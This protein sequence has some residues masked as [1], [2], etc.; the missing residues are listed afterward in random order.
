MIVDSCEKAFSLGFLSYIKDVHTNY[1]QNCYELNNIDEDLDKNL[2]KILKEYVDIIYEY[3]VT[4]MSLKNTSLLNEFT[5]AIKGF[6]DY[7]D[8]YK[9]A[10]MRG[11]YE[12]NNI[13]DKGSSSDIYILKNELIKDNYQ[14]YMDFVGIPYIVDDENKILIKY[15]CSSVDFL[16]F[17]YNNIENS[18]SFVY[19]NYKLSLPK[20]SVVKVDDNAIIPSKK[21]WS[22]VG[23]DLSIIKKIEDYNSKTALYDT[24]IK[25]QVDY[26]YYVEIVPRSSLAKTG[27]MLAN[28][29]GI[30]DNSYR[31]N[32]MVA[33]TKVCDDAKEIEYPFRC[34]QLI[35]RQQVNSTLEEVGNVDK[36]KRNEGGFGST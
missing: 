1:S 4:S 25:I 15:G 18:H 10:F 13:T 12:Y 28:S 34:C 2:L 9:R 22:D 3:G 24:G 16:G 31:G 35:L 8:D 11:I 36:T 14:S 29:I 5:D 27:Y 17:I 33:L 6:N 20:I 23:Y 21:N 7:K 32:L 26:E 30:I 19:N